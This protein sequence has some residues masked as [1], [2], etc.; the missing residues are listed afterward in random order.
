MDTPA[1]RGYHGDHGSQK[2]YR[3]YTRSRKQ[4]V[5]NSCQLCYN[6]SCQEVI[7]PNDIA[8]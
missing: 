7:K 1:E 4:L 2:G 8:L 5:T 6:M 3:S